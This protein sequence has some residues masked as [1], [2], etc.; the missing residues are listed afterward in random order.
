MTSSPA[1]AAADH[2]E[3]FEQLA[4]LSALDVLQGNERSAF[5]AHASRC[6]RC[7][8]I[9][10][11]DRQS[12]AGLAVAA[13]PMDPSPDFKARLMQRA[14]A[15][16]AEADH[17]APGADVGPTLPEPIT[18]RPRHG[19]VV[20]FYRRAWA[21]AIA[22]VLVLGIA[23]TGV[24]QYL[25]QPVATYTLSGDAPGTATVVVRRNGSIELELRGV[26][27][28]PPGRVYEAWIIPPGQQPVAAG[29]TSRGSATLPLSGQARG[30]TVAITDELA[31]GVQAPSS[32]PILAATVAS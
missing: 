2:S 7:Q 32:A 16:L 23:T 31:P 29:T 3:E 12:L 18:L 26:P 8:V 30:S 14:A 21:T 11:L 1:N 6:E 4:G 15:E 20:P 24:L 25:S 22:A 9:V 5:E 28:P 17:A 19:N 10:R 13:E 27:D